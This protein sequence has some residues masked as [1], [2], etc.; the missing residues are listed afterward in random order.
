[1]VSLTITRWPTQRVK[2]AA[3][4]TICATWRDITQRK[5]PSAPFDLI[6]ASPAAPIARSYSGADLIAS[7]NETNLLQTMRAS[8][9]R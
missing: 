6:I 2:I 1:M 9:S 3:K 8:K 4:A 7:K 5:R